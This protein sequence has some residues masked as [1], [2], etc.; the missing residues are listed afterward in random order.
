MVFKNV[1]GS[2]KTFNVRRKKNMSSQVRSNKMKIARI[3]SRFEKKFVYAARSYTSGLVGVEQHTLNGLI[4]GN[5]ELQRIGDSVTLSGL[6]FRFWTTNSGAPTAQIR[7]LIIVDT[8]NDNA[9]SVRVA[10]EFF[11]H[12]AGTDAFMSV[13]NKSLVSSK[14]E[15]KKYQILYDSGPLEQASGS[16]ITTRSVSKNIRLGHKIAFLDNDGTAGDII[17]NHIFVWCIN[18]N[19]NI[20]WG[21]SSRISFY[22]A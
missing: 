7:F 22:D 15:K 18:S 13:Y 12:V 1:R 10:T 5:T 17:N 11:A 2:T 16:N 8:I 14:G 3:N 9:D 21:F 4:R 20:K 19:T 6:T